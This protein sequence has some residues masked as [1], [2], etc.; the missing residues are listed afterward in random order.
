MCK[1]AP[2]SVLLNAKGYI[3]NKRCHH[4]KTKPA[5]R[6][7]FLIQKHQR[8]TWFVF[9]IYERSRN[10]CSTIIMW[11]K[12]KTL[13]FRRAQTL[14]AR[15]TGCVLF[16]LFIYLIFFC[17]LCAQEWKHQS[18]PLWTCTTEP[19]ILNGD[20]SVLTGD[21]TATLGD[22][23]LCTVH[24][25]PPGQTDTIGLTVCVCVCCVWAEHVGD[26]LQRLEGDTGSF[27]DGDSPDVTSGQTTHTHTLTVF[28][29]KMKSNVVKN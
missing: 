7:G 22:R 5:C 14:H 3:Q 24:I 4:S 26:S 20:K 13:L 11:W 18:V 2:K 6:E 19:S 23:D 27:W 9:M 16:D 17:P 15:V 1:I 28:Q 10:V 29:I 8:K 12:S 25:Y 21:I